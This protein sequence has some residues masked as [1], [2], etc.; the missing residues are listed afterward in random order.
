[1][2]EARIEVA[3]EEAGSPSVDVGP[4]STGARAIP[5][6]VPQVSIPDERDAV[7]F[8][9]E[10]DGV[11]EWAD[12]AA[13]ME[14]E[15]RALQ[16]KTKRARALLVV[17]ELLAMIGDEERAQTLAEE[18]RDLAP[19]LAMPHR[20]ARARLVR[21]RSFERLL[22]PLE[23]ESKTSGTAAGRAH[24]LILSAEILR[25]ISKDREAATKKLDQAARV[26]PSDPRPHLL[27]VAFELGQGA[28]SSRY[29]WPEDPALASL[30]AATHLL[31]ALR[32][33]F[34][35]ETP[36]SSVA[37]A[38]PRIRAAFAAGDIPGAAEAL[39]R[40][41]SKEG[42]GQAA[43][44]LASI[45][46]APRPA[47][48]SQALRWATPIAS[49]DEAIRRRLAFWSFEAGNAEKAAE[50]LE[51]QEAFS[52]AERTVAQALLGAEPSSLEASLQ[53]LASE[54]ATLP[55]ASALA[56]SF[57][58]TSPP[59]VGS[60]SIRAASALG[61]GLALGG[62]AAQSAI[63]AAAEQGP[64][65]PV[66][67]TLLLDA[68][69]AAKNGAGVATSLAAWPRNEDASADF[70]RDRALAAAVVFALSNA[71]E[72]ALQELENAK[73]TDPLHEATLRLAGT[74]APK[75]I[76]AGL[77][78]LA[79]EIEDPHRRSLLLL[80]AAV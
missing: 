76:A 49:Q 4:L 38:M 39:A 69:V 18:A 2:A 37:E 59:E 75:T 5:A 67:Q 53:K 26:L 51:D 57:H 15:A 48:R 28:Q 19:S 79:A 66:A 36:P 17:S 20:Q 41:P 50:A 74:L 3:A 78:A 35:K 45:L 63:L 11:Q 22:A 72:Q 77:D 7:A 64:E 52:L 23:V 71:N 43:L 24:A 80:E 40:L 12:R 58:L 9:A 10:V 1:M 31:S 27:R 30:A 13:W 14:V 73:Q 21:E 68:Q 65:D 33:A 44:W 46:A 60:P 61:R 54:E 6:V 62:E 16:D 8:I 55:L 56:S 32:G 25:H 29:R 42:V 47:T 70:D 34:D